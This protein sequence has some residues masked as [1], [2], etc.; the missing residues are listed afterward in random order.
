MSDLVGEGGCS[1]GSFAVFRKQPQHSTLVCAKAVVKLQETIEV[2]CEAESQGNTARHLQV[3]DALRDAE[4]SRC[5]YS[6]WCFGG[7]CTLVL[8]PA[9]LLVANRQTV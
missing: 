8:K 7:P 4:R 5:Q 9:P 1:G 6:C 2:E 3:L